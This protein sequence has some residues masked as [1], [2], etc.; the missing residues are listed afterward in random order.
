MPDT[1]KRHKINLILPVIQF[2]SYLKSLN[3]IINNEAIVSSQKTILDDFSQ[4]YSKHFKQDV[5]LMNSSDISKKLLRRIGGIQE[6]SEEKLTPGE[7]NELL[8]YRNKY[9]H[10]HNRVMF[11]Y[12]S[13]LEQIF[14][15]EN[16]LSQDKKQ[17]IYNL[18][19]S[20]SEQDSS[21]NLVKKLNQIN[22]SFELEK[23]SSMI[24]KDD[25]ENHALLNQMSNWNQN[26]I[27]ISKII[28]NEESLLKAKNDIGNVYLADQASINRE[29]GEENLQSLEE[30]INSLKNQRI[31]GKL[32]IESEF[33]IKSK[34]PIASLDTGTL[35]SQQINSSLK[36]ILADINARRNMQKKYN[37]KLTL[38]EISDTTL[39][40]AENNSL[41]ENNADQISIKRHLGEFFADTQENELLAVQDQ[42]IN[43]VDNFTQA[44][45]VF[46]KLFFLQENPAQIEIDGIYDP[47]KT[48]KQN[49][50]II[51]PLIAQGRF[52]EKLLD[53]IEACEVSFGPYE[54]SLAITEKNAVIENIREVAKRTGSSLSNPNIQLNL[55]FTVKDKD[56]ND[57]NIFMPKITG[58]GEHALMKFNGLGREFLRIIQESVANSSE[59]SG[60]LR[61][62][63]EIGS[64]FDRKKV[65]GVKDLG[66][67]YG[68][69]YLQEDN[70]K[71]AFLNHKSLAAKNDT[72]R[73][74]VI[75]A[76]SEEEKTD[77]IAVCEIR[78]IGNNP[79]LARF[80]NSY[81]VDS[82]GLDF[83]TETLLPKITKDLSNFTAT[84][85]DEELTALLEQEVNMSY[86]GRIEG[87]LASKI[88]ESIIHD[89]LF[90]SASHK[91]ST[92][93]LAKNVSQD[94]ITLLTPKSSLLNLSGSDLSSRNTTIS[95]VSSE[96]NL[97]R[98]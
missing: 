79:H 83:I 53:M 91:N 64:A 50:Q 49:L 44:E 68:S 69:P 17:E 93:R 27:E 46:Y 59:V 62:Q 77:G 45:T 56:G 41:T 87:L 78:L 67:L 55:S 61:N 34:E 36:E 20:I 5:S 22:M 4:Y 32:G 76:N 86:D 95:R 38:P 26:I 81:R 37:A 15:R 70:S 82:N 10:A 16:T 47:N 3:Q 43:Q 9:I 18:I 29:I 65:I 28:L 94:D 58:Q 90:D 6:G 40:F 31:E 12:G 1:E 8:S 11:N 52:H 98:K 39:L 14:N 73:L 25:L 24:E 13:F 84:K 71:P 63:T 23:H 97:Q 21:D 88:T 42:S 7:T 30:N 2:S 57:R 75:K 66:P 48:P 54:L 80:N 72:L 60:L 89:N 92:T 85:T 35:N 74:S 96:S 19:N 33:L 51:A